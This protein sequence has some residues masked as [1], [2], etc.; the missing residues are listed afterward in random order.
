MKETIKAKSFPGGGLN[1]DGYK[2]C[3]AEINTL[4]KNMKS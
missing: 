3:I 1:M 2:D 4:N